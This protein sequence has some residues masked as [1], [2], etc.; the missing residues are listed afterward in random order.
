MEMSVLQDVE[1]VPKWKHYLIAS[2]SIT[3]VEVRKFYRS[4]SRIISNTF[5]NLLFLIVFLLM[6]PS[7]GGVGY[8][9]ELR[10]LAFTASGLIVQPI[11]FSGIMM[12]MGVLIDKQFGFFKEIQVSPVP[13]TSIV[14]GRMVGGALNCVF[15][16]SIVFTIT[17]LFGAYSFDPFLILRILVLIPVFLFFAMGVIGIGLVITTSLKDMQAFGTVMSF[18]VMP[19]FFLSGVF[20]PIN[21][22][23]LVFQ[24][25]LLINPAVYAVDIFRF[26][27]T[28]ICFLPIGLDIIGMLCFTLGFMIL[29]AILFR[30]MDFQ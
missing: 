10:G 25:L 14:V 13:R 18:L 3:K 22:L 20:F 7:L 8:G 5:S 19:M 6:G 2:W 12:A 1:Y 24:F 11:L 27:L 21:S 9:G 30:R 23:P 4:K 15:Q 29:G 26:I 17:V 16:A 28:G